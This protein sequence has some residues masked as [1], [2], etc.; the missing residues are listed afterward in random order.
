MAKG[1]L[2]HRTKQV[3]VEYQCDP[4]KHQLN[5]LAK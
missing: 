3:I 2:Y 4:F 5:A 1:I